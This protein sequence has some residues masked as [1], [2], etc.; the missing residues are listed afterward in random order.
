MK[1]QKMLDLICFCSHS[2]N[3]SNLYETILQVDLIHPSLKKFIFTLLSN[4]TFTSTSIE[5]Q[6]VI[7]KFQIR[8]R[9]K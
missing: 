8:R 4:V 2:V 1:E 6:S 5:K 3:D 7:F 9:E